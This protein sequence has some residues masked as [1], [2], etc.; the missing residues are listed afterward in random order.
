MSPLTWNPPGWRL[1]A[2][3]GLQ[4]QVVRVE[5]DPTR[6][7]E[8]AGERPA[9]VVSRESI[10]SA[11]TVVAI[12]PITTRRPGRRIHSTEV[13]LPAGTA[14][15]PNESVVM[16]QQIRTISKERIGRT[17]GRLDEEGL[18][19]AVRDAIRTYLDLEY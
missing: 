13:L 10:N 6:G 17:Y 15:L 4:W 16:A 12:L 18:Q 7:S 14:G 5:L 9:L 2:D 1:M 8:Q 19:S 11:L 3:A